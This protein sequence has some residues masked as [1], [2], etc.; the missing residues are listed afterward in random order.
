MKKSISILSVVV[1]LVLQMN[2]REYAQEFPEEVSVINNFV[3]EQIPVVSTA[4]FKAD[5]GETP[6][7]KDSWQWI[8]IFRRLWQ[9]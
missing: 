9:F 7:W 1:L 5:G 2:C 8:Q 6:P 4:S 3:A